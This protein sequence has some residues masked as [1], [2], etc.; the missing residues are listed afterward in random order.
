MLCDV[1]QWPC[2]ARVPGARGDV[3]SLQRTMPQ[4]RNQL[5]FADVTSMHLGGAG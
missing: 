5:C 1:K 3:D 4:M 2:F